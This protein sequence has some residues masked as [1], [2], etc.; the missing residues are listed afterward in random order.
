MIKQWQ[1]NHE[2]LCFLNNQKASFDSSERVRLH[3]ELLIPWQKLRLLDTDAAMLFLQPFYSNTGRPALNQPQILRSFILFFLL[4]S[5]GLASPS[6]TR[7]VSRLKNDRV[8]AALIGCHTHSLPPLG[9]YFDFMDR[10][11]TAP[12]TDRYRRNKLLPASWNSKKPK[13]PKGKG[14]KASE[15]KPLITQKLVDRIMNG[16]DILF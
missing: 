10:L 14:Q 13:K 7:W 5:M 4:V 15:S 3:S 16:K 11:W 1:S 2:Y 9:S 12:E 8:L 6:L